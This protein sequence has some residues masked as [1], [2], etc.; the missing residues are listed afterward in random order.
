M[1][2]VT[3]LMQWRLRTLL[4]LFIAGS[5]TLFATV[6]PMTVIVDFDAPLTA[7]PLASTLLLVGSS[8]LVA[9]AGSL[10]RQHRGA[11]AVDAPPPLV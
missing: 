3:R 6:C 4:R 2:G 10:L 9:L 11:P 5:I 7:P 8:T 1:Q